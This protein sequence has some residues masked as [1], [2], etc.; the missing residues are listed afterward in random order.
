MVA[1]DV[2]PAA[3]ARAVV[4]GEPLGFGIDQAKTLEQ[5]LHRIIVTSPDHVT[6]ERNVRV[7][8]NRMTRVRVRL[9]EDRF[10]V[11]PIWGTLTSIATAVLTAGTIYYG[12]RSLGAASEYR[13][14][15]TPTS[16]LA[17]AFADHDRFARAANNALAGAIIFGIGSALLYYWSRGGAPESTGRIDFAPIE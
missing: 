6:F 14:P 3:G 10:Y 1:L 15:Q 7:R 8:A 17:G 4:D 13:D 9:T 11:A 12:A 5:G 16:R 2:T